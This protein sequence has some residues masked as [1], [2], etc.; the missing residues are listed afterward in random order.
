MVTTDYIIRA[1]ISYLQRYISSGLG[2]K[3]CKKC[4]VNSYYAPLYLPLT[5]LLVAHL[6]C[7][8]W[9]AYIVH[10]Q[11]KRTGTEK[12][13]IRIFVLIIQSIIQLIN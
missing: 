9:Y 1:I 11:D 8:K 2:C 12:I 7:G 3:N 13:I 4:T 5:T 6:Q 10:P